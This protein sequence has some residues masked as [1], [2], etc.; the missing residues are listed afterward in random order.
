[1]SELEKEMQESHCGFPC[2][3]LALRRTRAGTSPT[4]KWR[5]GLYWP[6]ELLEKEFRAIIESQKSTYPRLHEKTDWLLFGDTKEYQKSGKTFHVFHKATEGA[7]S[8][9]P[10]PSLGTLRQS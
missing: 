7:Q 2:Q 6:R 5:R 4:D 10:G 9:H 1:M 8:G 3:L